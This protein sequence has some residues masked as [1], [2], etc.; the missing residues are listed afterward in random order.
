MSTFT[1]PAT[2]VKQINTKT[3]PSE[4]IRDKRKKI[5][6]SSIGQGIKARFG[7]LA[8]GRSLPS[9]RGAGPKLA[10]RPS[11]LPA[12]SLGSH[13]AQWPLHRSSPANQDEPTCPWAIF[14]FPVFSNS[15]HL[16]KSISI[17]SQ[18]RKLWNHFHNFCKNL[19]YL[20]VQSL[21]SFELVFLL[22]FIASYWFPLSAFVFRSDE[23]CLDGSKDAPDRGDSHWSAMTTLGY[24]HHYFPTSQV[25]W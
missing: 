13:L 14:P 19:L 4:G 6:K 2:I 1:L 21:G 15:S 22:R 3:L 20:L 16:W 7:P 25:S 23:L 17:L 11:L 24:M 18:L 10:K 5:T 9:L 12:C 8:Q